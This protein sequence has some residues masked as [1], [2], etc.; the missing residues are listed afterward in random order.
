MKTPSLS[1]IQLLHTKSSQ[2]KKNSL[3]REGYWPAS[4]AHPISPFPQRTNGLWGYFGARRWGGSS[5][6]PSCLLAV[7]CLLSWQWK[8]PLAFSLACAAT[9]SSNT[10]ARCGSCPPASRV[11]R[12]PVL[13]PHT[14]F[15]FSIRAFT[16]KQESSSLG[17]NR[18]FMVLFSLP[19]ITNTAVDGSRWHYAFLQGAEGADELFKH[20]AAFMQISLVKSGEIKQA[21]C[22]YRIGSEEAAFQQ[23]P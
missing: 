4:L 12:F 9:L 13:W 20:K 8:W 11:Q 16:W 14:Y 1:F 19:K 7:F 17:E 23:L 2:H 22:V 10:R 15:F 5:T 18:C 6:K 3:A 21:W